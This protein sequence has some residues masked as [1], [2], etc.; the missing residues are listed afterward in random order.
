[1][2]PSDP[3]ER[4]QQ[5]AQ[6]DTHDEHASHASFS[7]KRSYAALQRRLRRRQTSTGRGLRQTLFLLLLLATTIYF[8]NR[9]AMI[10]DTVASPVDS[11][12]ESLPPVVID[13]SPPTATISPTP[14]PPTPLP[15]TQTPLALPSQTALPA[16]TPTITLQANGSAVI[17]GA[18][19]SPVRVRVQPGTDQR[20]VARLKEGTIVHILEGPQQAAGLAWWRIERGGTRGWVAAP[21]LQ[22][23]P[24]PTPQ[25][26]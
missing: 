26:Q 23:A 6:A 10:G 18:E 22:P 14:L 20:I 21:Y 3:A 1:M 17:G 24:T 5:E 19:G 16:P 15:P 25:G 9:A 12:A 4:G 8:S 11:T 2:M 13:I 7:F